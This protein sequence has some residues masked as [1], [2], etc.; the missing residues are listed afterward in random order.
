MD[1][2]ALQ[3]QEVARRRTGRWAAQPILYHR[4]LDSTNTLAAR[5]VP[6]QAPP[7]AVVVADYQYG[8][9]GRLARRWLVEPYSALTFTVV[10]GPLAP[11]WTAPMVCGLAAVQA[12]EAL[13]MPA[14]LK[15]PNDLLV[16]GKK[17]GG[18]LIETKPVAN[19]SWL[20]AGI[21]INVRSVDPGLDGAT[22][23]DAH[24]PTPVRRED[25][26][27]D[28]LARLD[29]WGRRAETDGDAVREAWRAHLETLGRWVAVQ[30]PAGMLE[31]LATA[32]AAD[33]GL[34]V[35][36]AD[37]SFR[38]VQAGDVTLSPRGSG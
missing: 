6:Q 13:A 7:G 26:L 9:R 20:L 8:G 10:L 4:E 28:L 2:R 1:T 18:I 5:L 36:L 29:E 30:T 27:A 38:T 25:L 11:A 17:C 31:G 34:I 3:W 16:G 35:R 14:T 19:A 21:G 24:T 12:I 15:W 32:V 37:G 22:Y 33:G 23:L